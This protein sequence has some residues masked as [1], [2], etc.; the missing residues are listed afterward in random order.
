MSRKCTTSHVTCTRKHHGF[1]GYRHKPISTYAV[2]SIT[3]SEPRSERNTLE[4]PSSRGLVD[5]LSL[6]FPFAPYL[7]SSLPPRDQTAKTTFRLEIQ[8]SLRVPITVLPALFSYLLS[9]RPLVALQY[10]IQPTQA[11]TTRQP[12]AH[13]FISFYLSLYMLTPILFVPHR[14]HPL[15]RRYDT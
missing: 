8:D 10:N 4:H 1:N 13:C 6:R 5:I 7:V 9:H 11:A 3:L 12:Y 15:S 2:L 14:Q